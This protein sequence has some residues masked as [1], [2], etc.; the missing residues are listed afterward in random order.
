MRWKL[1]PGVAKVATLA[2][3][4]LALHLLCTCYRGDWGTD[5]RCEICCFRLHL[6]QFLIR[7]ALC[8]IAICPEIDQT[9]PETA[10]GQALILKQIDQDSTRMLPCEITI[11]WNHGVLHVFND[12]SSL[13]LR[14]LLRSAETAA[15]CLQPSRGGIDQQGFDCF[16][17]S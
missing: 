12:L 7:G 10:G 4:C 5:E 6:F 13:S 2:S 9:F 11:P 1:L 3:L 17:M 15:T 14:D 16:L 8:G